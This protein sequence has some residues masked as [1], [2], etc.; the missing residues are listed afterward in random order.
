M[1]NHIYSIG[2]DRL[3]HK[4]L[5]GAMRSKPFITLLSTGPIG[6]AIFW[7]MIVFIV[8]NNFTKKVYF[9]PTTAPIS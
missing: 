8:T 1:P 5:V 6:P 4:V 2:N 9:D 3:G 7:L